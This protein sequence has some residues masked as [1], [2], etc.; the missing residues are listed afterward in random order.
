MG[1]DDF[2]LARVRELC[3]YYMDHY[4]GPRDNPR[5]EIVMVP[6]KREI[7]QD[8]WLLMKTKNL[9]TLDDAVRYLQ[10]ELAKTRMELED[11][12]KKCGLEDEVIGDGSQL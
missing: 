10:T 8:L 7:Y 5:G 9:A 3:K 11:L 2:L 12:K 4:L 6:L 1:R